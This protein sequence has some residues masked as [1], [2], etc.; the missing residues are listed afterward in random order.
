[1]SAAGPLGGR[2]LRVAIDGTPLLGER[3]GIGHVT[4]NLVGALAARADVSPVVYVVSRTAARDLDGMLPARARLGTSRLP[5]RV[6]LPL[7]ERWRWPPIE[8]WTGRIDVVHATNYAAPPARAPVVVTVHD[9][10]YIQRPDLVSEHSRRFLGN[11]VHRA[12]ERGATI[13]VV[14]DFVGDEVLSAYRLPESRVV[15]VYPGIAETADGDPR[16]GRVLAGA[17]DYVLA[18]GQLEPRKNLPALVRAFDRMASSAPDLRLVVAGPDGWGRDEFEAAVRAA[19]ARDRIVWLGYVTDD[20]RRALLAGARCFAYPSLYEG[21]GHPPLEAMA[22]GIPVVAANSGAIP[23]ITGGAALVVDPED[24]DTL[25]DALVAA[26]GDAETRDRL[27]RDGL[28]RAAQF[29]WKTAT[30]EFVALYARLASLS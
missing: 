1:M 12:V 30:D 20:E 26:S 21:F 19:R 5:A 29:D 9:L 17:D 7:W 22:A 23:E 25:A 6:V 8:R 27:A 3:T 14:S 2:S 15:R 11:L 24:T 18:L 16:A 13:H 4:A 10:T 28:A